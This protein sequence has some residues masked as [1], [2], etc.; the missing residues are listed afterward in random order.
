VKDGGREER[1]GEAVDASDGV[2]RRIDEN[3]DNK[4]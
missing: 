1:R 3:E 4:C 2:S